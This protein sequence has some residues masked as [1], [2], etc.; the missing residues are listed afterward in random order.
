MT[1]ILDQL[2]DL[3][4]SESKFK[5]G[6]LFDK[7]KENSALRNGFAMIFDVINSLIDKNAGVDQPNENIVSN[8]VSSA[9]VLSLLTADLDHILGLFNR[10]QK[11][12]CNLTLS[13]AT[14]N[15]LTRLSVKSAGSLATGKIFETQPT[16]RFF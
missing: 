10:L 3:F 1:E 7:M 15:I 13:S 4:Q 12:K 16:D 14:C 8:A 5:V 2:L 6:A 11:L 9:L